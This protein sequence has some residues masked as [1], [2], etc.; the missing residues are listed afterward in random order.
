MA[1]LSTRAVSEGYVLDRPVT[2]VERFGKNLDGY[3]GLIED[4]TEKQNKAR[5]E[6]IETVSGSV[7]CCRWSTHQA[8]LVSAHRLLR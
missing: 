1:V 3:A 4:G 5:A 8:G 7:G 2:H 6:I